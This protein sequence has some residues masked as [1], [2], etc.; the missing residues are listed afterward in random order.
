MSQSTPRLVPSWN[1]TLITLGI[2]RD[3]NAAMFCP[4]F[5]V[6]LPS[7]DEDVTEGPTFLGLGLSLTIPLS[8]LETRSSF[9]GLGLTLAGS[10]PT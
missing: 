5:P 4:G 1:Y 3:T 10:L 2:S 6:E 8:A 7:G 9:L